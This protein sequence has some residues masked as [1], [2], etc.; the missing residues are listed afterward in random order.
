[1]SLGRCSLLSTVQ[2]GSVKHEPLG[3]GEAEK[4]FTT[5]SCDMSACS[6]L[7]R[8]ALLGMIQLKPS[9]LEPSTINNFPAS[10]RELQHSSLPVTSGERAHCRRKKA[11][12]KSTRFF[13]EQPSTKPSRSRWIKNTQVPLNA[14]NILP[15]IQP[16]RHGRFCEN[17]SPPQQA[18]LSKGFL[19]PQP[20]HK[21]QLTTRGQIGS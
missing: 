6:A 18:S 5:Q 8:V 20:Q 17:I 2:Q 7:L 11:P 1:M 9:G 12:L 19:T 14:G 13:P 21:L 16:G 15:T 3:A 10:Q 4:L